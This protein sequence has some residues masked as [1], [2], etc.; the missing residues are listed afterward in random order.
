M[1]KLIH[2][3]MWINLEILHWVKAESPQ[4]SL[5]GW[6]HLCKHSMQVKY[7]QIE[8]FLGLETWILLR[9]QW[10]RYLGTS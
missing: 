3:A 2:T 10:Q 1:V 4:K 8:G 7:V 9:E 5:T 6:L